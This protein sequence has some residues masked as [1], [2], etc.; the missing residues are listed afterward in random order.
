MARP[1][2]L[3]RHRLKFITFFWNS[4][5]RQLAIELF[6]PKRTPIYYCI[7]LLLNPSINSIIN[8]TD[9]SQLPLAALYLSM[10][11]G[12]M[13]PHIVEIAQ[14]SPSPSPSPSPRPSPVPVQSQLGADLAITSGV[15]SVGCLFVWL[16]EDFFQLSSNHFQSSSIDST[17][18]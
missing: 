4:S 12:L 3:F 16:V 10:S 6:P 11:D 2:P 5:L 13:V 1:P 9:D 7:I 8:L 15:W 14:L 18:Q 17:I